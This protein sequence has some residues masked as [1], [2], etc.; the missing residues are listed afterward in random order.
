M[1][2]TIHQL[3][4]FLKV[5][6]SQSI[7]KASKKLFMTQPAVSIQLKKFQDQFEIPLTEVIGRQLNITPFGMEIAGLAKRIMTEMDQIKYKTEAY[8]GL[9][10]GKLNLSSASTGMYVMP[11]FLAGF[12]EQ[13]PGIDLVLDVTN[14]GNVMER[15]ANNETDF[16]LISVIPEG[17]QLNEEILID[18]HLYLVSNHPE[19]EKSKPLIYRETGSATRQAMESYY[20]TE[21]KKIR[22]QLELTSTEAVKQAVIAGLGNSILPLIGIH[23]ELNNGQL[24]I[25]KSKGLPIKTEWRLVWLRGKRLSPVSDAFLNYIRSK[26]EDIIKTHFGWHDAYLQQPDE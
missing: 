1:N 2:Y 18:N 15:L 16:A 25:L 13:H 22:K 12:L 5:V 8:K 4:V 19:K 14:K 23:N 6:E 11:F 20:V 17:Y 10:T 21:D 9:V 26:K 24:H 7:T 3:Q